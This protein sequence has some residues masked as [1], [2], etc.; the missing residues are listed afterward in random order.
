MADFL[1]SQVKREISQVAPVTTECLIEPYL[2]L[3]PM[4]Q[5]LQL[6]ALDKDNPIQSKNFLLRAH[7]SGKNLKGIQELIVYVLTKRIPLFWPK[8]PDIRGIKIQGPL[9]LTQK[10]VQ[11]K[12]KQI[13]PPPPLPELKCPMHKVPAEVVLQIGGSSAVPFFSWVTAGH[14]SDAIACCC[15]LLRIYII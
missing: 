7:I 9:L 14:R 4:S 11:G 1:C 13:A 10:L 3:F 6:T 15:E 5:S 8:L 12:D 2:G